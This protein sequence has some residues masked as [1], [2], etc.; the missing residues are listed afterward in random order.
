MRYSIKHVIIGLVTLMFIGTMIAIGTSLWFMAGQKD[1]G[2][3]INMSGK[4]R[5]LSQKISKSAMIAFHDKSADK[6]TR[7]LEEAISLYEENL[8][9]LEARAGGGMGDGFVKELAALK[10]VWEPFRQEARKLLS[11]SSEQQGQGL[12][13]IKQHN[14]ELLKQANTLTSEA[15]ASLAAKQGYFKVFLYLFFPGGM[16]VLFVAW[17]LSN[18]LI[19]APIQDALSIIMTASSGKFDSHIE[20]K[21]AAEMQDIATAFNALIA[22]IAG[23]IMTIA[24]QSGII[25][26]A[27]KSFEK[28][29]K[30]IMHYGDSMIGTANEL[31]VLATD[32]TSKLDAVSISTND[33][34][35]ATSEIAQSVSI[36]AR[37]TNE[38]HAQAGQASSAITRLSESSEKINNIIKVINNIASQ[39]NLLALNATIEAAR[40]GE[41]GKGFAVVANEV[42]ELARQ[43]AEATQ[44]ITSMI[45]AIQADTQGAVEAVEGIAK[46]VAEVNDLANTIASATEEQTATVSEMSFNITHSAQS[47]VHVKNSAEQLAEMTKEFQYVKEDL[48]SSEK[49]ME[50]IY[51]ESLL[52]TS[53]I[54]ITPSLMDRLMLFLPDDAKVKLATYQHLVWRDKVMAGVVSGEV[55]EVETDGHKCAFGRF[56]D[57]FSHS[58]SE[59]NAILSKVKPVH[60]KLHATVIQVQKMT[61]EGAKR[62][63]LIRL[64][65]SD[66]EPV[67][68]QVMGYLDSL[69]HILARERNGGKPFQATA[70]SAGYTHSHSHAAC[71]AN[72]SSSGGQFMNWGPEFSCGI[73]SIDEQHKKL[74]RMVNEIYDAIQTGKDRQHLGKILNE[75]VAYTDYHFKYEEEN[76]KKHKYP[77]MQIHMKVHAD[78]VAKVLEFKEKFDKGQAMLSHDILNFLKS[79]L[80]SH[81]CVTDKKYGPYL[82]GKGVV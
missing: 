19:I 48:H 58:S 23:Q 14:L 65:E 30:D 27:R 71:T 24:A 6:S 59:V 10:S 75:L 82:K 15:E 67:M 73:P 35:T 44:E 7:E 21:G 25:E 43:T 36:T 49:A 1:D 16:F 81:I 56:L 42:K 69:Y 55:P 34:T 31:D 32:S 37:K 13:Y 64:Y 76:F 29:N 62:S 39:T 70:S 52:L 3:V 11:S 45:Q 63:D 57:T 51:K 8:K 41:A 38:A 26:K 2:A 54:N 33:M 12:D 17:F 79:W 72:V 77:E 5:M 18:R 46:G 50:T 68:A 80:T 74:L 9:Q 61:V 40:A 4:A 66:I 28:T 78:L 20:P 22:N 53:L 60:E 47:A